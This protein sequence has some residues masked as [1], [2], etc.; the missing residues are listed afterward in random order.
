MI[1]VAIIGAGINGSI[2]AYFLKKQG[3]DVCVFDS[4]GCAGGGSGA[5]GAFLSPKFLKSG[6]VKEIL[7]S[8]LDEAFAFYEKNFLKFISRYP[9]LH[10]AKDEKDA[11]NIAYFKTHNDIELLQNPPFIPK[12]EYIFTSKSAIIDAKEMIK[13]LLFETAFKNEE[14]IKLEK[15]DDVWVLNDSYKAKKVVLATGAYSDMVDEAYLKTA[16]RGIWGHRIDVKTKTKNEIS[17]HQFVSVSPNKNN[18]ISIGAT[19]DV[20]FNPFNMEYD[21][22]KGRDELIKKA[23]MS[24]SALEVE[25]ILKDYVGLRSGSSDYL[26]IIGKVVNSEKTLK[27]LSRRELEFKKQDFS[28]Y[29]YYD[30]LYMIN[31]SAGY[32]FVLAPYLGRALSELIINKTPVDKKIDIARFFARYARRMF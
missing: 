30:G 21:F 7:N 8:S 11:K 23:K 16:L 25:D 1:D 4:R 3:L 15:K 29:E 31:G 12:N 20:H 10:V 13:A 24:F 17:I 2:T 6:D 27:K 32:G 28:K 5:A 18:I 14:I 26:P 19:H 22:K 9:L